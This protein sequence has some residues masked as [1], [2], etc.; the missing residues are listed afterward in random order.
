[1]KPSYSREK[2]KGH[3]TVENVICA[4]LRDKREEGT[5]ANWKNANFEGWYDAV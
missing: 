5:L 4:K 3:L 1:M 2:I